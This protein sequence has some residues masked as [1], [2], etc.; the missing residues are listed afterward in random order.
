[1]R[2]HL[3]GAYGLIFVPQN[4]TVR[5]S[6]LPIIPIKQKISLKKL[7]SLGIKGKI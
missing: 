5:R 6:F 4:Q 3:K 7:F 1:M 2:V